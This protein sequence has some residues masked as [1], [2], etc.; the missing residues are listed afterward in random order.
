MLEN[1]LENYFKIEKAYRKVF[2]EEVEK[3]Q[4]TPN[5]VL[6]ILFLY[7]NG[8]S[9]NTAKDIARYEGVSKG[10]IARSVDSLSEKGYLTLVRDE[11]DRRVI[12]LHLTEHCDEIVSG[13]AEK[14]K[15]FLACIQKNIPEEH[16]R[17]T[18]ET[19]EHFLENASNLSL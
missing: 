3:Y 8:S 9:V 4:L 17:I 5:E 11:M 12:H 7:E 18:T 13:M 19:L 14:K 16:I 6:V 1:F 15:R 10:L 2:Q